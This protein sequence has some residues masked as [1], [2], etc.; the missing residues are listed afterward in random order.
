MSLI[1][2]SVKVDHQYERWIAVSKQ[3]LADGQVDCGEAKN[4]LVWYDSRK[5][6]LD[7]LRREINLEMRGIRNGYR[8][9]TAGA[10]VR[11]DKTRI[12]NEQNVELAPYTELL[13]K[14]ER[15]MIEGERLQP[16]LET[17]IEKE[18]EG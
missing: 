12:R 11:G 2:L 1:E 3:A 5:K 10:K 16:T 14:I 8:V 6:E 9:K 17:F 13:S 7:L 18:C 4:W 15:L